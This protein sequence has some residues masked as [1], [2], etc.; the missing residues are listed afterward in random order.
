MHGNSGDIEYT[1]EDGYLVLH[2]DMGDVMIGPE[3]ME[4]LIRVMQG[5]LDDE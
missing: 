3:D 4:D 2:T 5:V 1:V